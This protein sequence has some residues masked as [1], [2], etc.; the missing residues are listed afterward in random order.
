MSI[1]DHDLTALNHSMWG[2]FAQV[3]SFDENEALTPESRIQRLEDDLAIKNLINKYTFCYDGS[4]LDRLMTVF[5]EHCTL[6][7]PRGIYVGKALIEKNYRHLISTRKFSFHHMTNPVV[8]FSQNGAEALL[9]CYF[10]C[11]IAFRSRALAGSSGTYVCKVKKIEG[12]WKITEMRITL[13]TR[14]SL[15]PAESAVI[16]PSSSVD[17][18]PVAPTPTFSE[19]TR[20]WIGP[21]SLA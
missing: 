16:A 4:D 20:E 13:N 7:N 12:L 8:K 11:V 10:N 15:T 21:E 17:A 5:D 19:N 14:Q 1:N 9:V 2:P 6:A 3:T 18:P